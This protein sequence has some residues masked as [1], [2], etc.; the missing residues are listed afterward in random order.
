[1][2]DGLNFT[3]VMST[4]ALHE[5]LRYIEIPIPYAERSGRSKLSVV[6]DGLRF[7]GTI[8]W[9]AMQYNPARFLEVGGL[10]SIGVAALIW[11]GLVAARAQGVTN[12]D[13]WGVVAVYLGLVLAVGGV[14][15]LSLGMA[16]NALVARSHS[17]PI[18][19]ESLLA[20]LVGPAIEQRFGL[21]GGFLSM[22]G[23]AMGVASIGLGLNGWA[24]ERIW[25]WLLGSALLLLVGVHL[26]LFWG[27]L[28]VLHTLDDRAQQ[29][30]QDMGQ[31]VRP[32]P[33]VAGRPLYQPDGTAVA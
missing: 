2:P 31:P 29:V 16:F 9:T 8:L 24:L 33:A 19:Q 6:R 17:G 26:V 20:K 11:M 4:R 10:S 32:E 27:L 1:L 15:V 30:G 14:S 23:L 3:P 28:R 7:L 12:L 22:S 18:R 25:L 5:G 21:I 13:A